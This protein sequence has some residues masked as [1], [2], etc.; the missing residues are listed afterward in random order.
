VK[1][2]GKRWV[3]PNGHWFKSE[4]RAYRDRCVP[5]GIQVALVSLLE[6]IISSDPR[7]HRVDDP[8]RRPTWPSFGATARAEQPALSD[9]DLWQVPGAR[10]SAEVWA[11]R[12][13][14]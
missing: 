13:G 3:R 11:E 7:T 6:L 10:A 12:H 5:A 4:F 1:E 8:R 14:A 9:M 2:T